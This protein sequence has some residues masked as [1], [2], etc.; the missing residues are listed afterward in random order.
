MPRAEFKGSITTTGR[1]EAI[2]LDKALFKAHPEFRQRARI[3]A[4]VMGPGT[5][6]VTLDPETAAEPEA[7]T[8]PVVRAYL[9]FL[10]RDM[11]DHPERLQPITEGLAERAGALVQ[12]VKVSPEETLPDD[13]TL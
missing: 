3:K 2:R 13:V 1:S 12:D 4:S 5:L 11:R 8:D 9:A 7:E 10:E 6:L